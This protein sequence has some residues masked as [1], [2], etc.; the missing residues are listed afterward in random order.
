[1]DR[2]DFDDDYVRRLK[3]RDRDTE[4]HFFAYFRE[5]L[6]SKLQRRLPAAEM[7]EDILQEVFKRVIASLGSVRD[8]RSF[9]A[10]VN[11]VARNVT[12]EH[13]RRYRDSV[14]LEE[15]HE[16]ISDG[17]DLYSNMVSA[18]TSARVRR[19]LDRM[20]ER[21][22]AL[23]RAVFMED[24]DKDE[25]C[26]RFGVYREY[27]RVLLHR[28]KERFR[29]EFGRKSIPPPTSLVTFGGWFSLWV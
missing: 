7:L 27:L 4:E 24:L 21:D 14:P 13:L 11:G 15:N 17:V 26:K 19:V 1:M 9:G 23:L 25:I 28:A 2:F 16:S 3:E 29:V 20:P 10:Y 22:A 18:E 12:L 8:G 5:R 6:R